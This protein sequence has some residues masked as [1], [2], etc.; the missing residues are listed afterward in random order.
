MDFEFDDC[1][2]FAPDLDTPTDW[3]TQTADGFDAGMGLSAPF[4]AVAIDPAQETGS[5]WYKVLLSAS[6]GGK[7]VTGF[8]PAAACETLAKLDGRTALNHI[9]ATLRIADTDVHANPLEEIYQETS[10]RAYKGHVTAGRV[11]IESDTRV[12]ATTRSTR[13]R[14]AATLVA[15]LVSRGI[16]PGLASKAVTTACGSEVSE[17]IVECVRLPESYAKRECAVAGKAHHSVMGMGNIQARLRWDD[18]MMSDR[19]ASTNKSVDFAQLTTVARFIGE[20]NVQMDTEGI[21]R[22]ANEGVPYSTIEGSLATIDS[23]RD[24]EPIAM[25]ASND[26]VTCTLVPSIPMIENE[27][28]EANYTIIRRALEGSKSGDLGKAEAEL[29][30][31]ALAFRVAGVRKRVQ[32]AVATDQIASIVAHKYSAEEAAEVAKQGAHAQFCVTEAIHDMCDRD[33]AVYTIVAEAAQQGIDWRAEEPHRAI[34]DFQ[35][36]LASPEVYDRARGK[37]QRSIGTL[38]NWEKRLIRYF[39]HLFG[40]SFY[41][42]TRGTLTTAMRKRSENACQGIARASILARAPRPPEYF[43]MVRLNPSS[44]YADAVAQ[45]ARVNAHLSV[46][47]AKWAERYDSHVKLAMHGSQDRVEAV[48]YGAASSAFQRVCPRDMLSTGLVD[49]SVPGDNYIADMAANYARKRRMPRPDF[50][51]RSFIDVYAL[52]TH[53]DSV[54]KPKLS[55]LEV[56]KF[57][58][59]RLAMLKDDLINTTGVGEREVYVAEKKVDPELAALDA[60]FGSALDMSVTYAS[61]AGTYPGDTQVDKIG[62]FNRAA[63]VN[64]FADGQRAFESLGQKCIYDEE[65]SFTAKYISALS[66]H[67]AVDETPMIV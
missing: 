36:L 40:V 39:N 13:A 29:L 35:E 17:A 66:E 64:G 16:D 18:A 12:W 48:K 28:A 2:W 3:A 43:P 62:A 8:A 30:A 14:T 55:F 51:G 34:H 37:M 31:N 26:A 10:G 53:L 44:T 67:I 47:A 25:I 19:L 54:Y 4:D 22:F 5:D 6:M 23:V 9:H 50:R 46:Y 58:E 56:H 38:D 32:R 45:A 33:A 1:D 41:D 42:K 7:V 11:V 24:A 59:G 52:A 15:S 60:L 65:N 57:V 61:V 49:V 27:V 63:V 21:E 20:A